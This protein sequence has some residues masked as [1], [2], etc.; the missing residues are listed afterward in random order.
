VLR[1]QLNGQEL[2]ELKISWSIFD[3]QHVLAVC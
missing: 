2:L 1:A 3:E